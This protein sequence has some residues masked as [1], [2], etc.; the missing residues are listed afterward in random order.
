MLNSSFCTKSSQTGGV[1]IFTQ[2]LAYKL[3]V[4]QCLQSFLQ[5]RS[6]VILFPVYHF[7]IYISEFE[8]LVWGHI[9]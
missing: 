5:L 3:C 6:L 7:V 2:W 4:E 9:Y 1:E 8:N